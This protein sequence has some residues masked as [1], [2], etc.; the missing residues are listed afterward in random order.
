MVQRCNA[1]AQAAGES[2]AEWVASALEIAMGN[3]NPKSLL[4]YADT[5]L[6]G[7]HKAGGRSVRGSKLPDEDSTLPAEI[8]IFQEATGRLP[9]RDQ[10]GMVIRAIQ[11]HGFSAVDLRPFW[12][13]HVARDK[14]RS[15]L[16]WLLDW[17]VKGAVPN[18]AGF[19]RPSGL[20]QMAQ[21]LQIL[22]QNS[23]PYK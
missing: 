15:D 11:E 7:W 21:T 3:A 12:E 9:L 8:A 19:N 1:T 18:A 13:A 2:G 16:T 4:N 14:K 6:S 5:V 10:R 20:D 22:S 23:L 17:A